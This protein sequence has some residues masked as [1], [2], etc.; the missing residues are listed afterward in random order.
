MV[1]NCIETQG[2][3]VPKTCEVAEGECMNV[4]CAGV[5][6]EGQE[7]RPQPFAGQAEVD[8][9][10]VEELNEAVYYAWKPSRS[11]SWLGGER[12]RW[13]RSLRPKG[14]N[15]CHCMVR[16]SECISIGFCTH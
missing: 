11:R 2:A 15:G 7:R 14:I 10:P 8:L 13:D 4:V 5:E 9:L 1:D 3:V 6:D 12:R 16:G